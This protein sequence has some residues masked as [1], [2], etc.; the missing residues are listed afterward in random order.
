MTT[1][2]HKSSHGYNV[3]DPTTTSVKLDD[4]YGLARMSASARKRG[5]S[6]VVDIVPNHVG[7]KKPEKNPL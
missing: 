2:G 3:T 6:L 7:S 1:A 5:K 4:I